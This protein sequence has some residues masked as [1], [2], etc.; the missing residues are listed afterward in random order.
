MFFTGLIYFCSG[1]VED[2]EKWGL[3][4]GNNAS[5]KGL[6]LYQNGV[7][8]KTRFNKRVVKVVECIRKLKLSGR[9]EGFCIQGT[10]RSSVRLTE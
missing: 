8:L 7:I 1:V 2:G 5:L 3:I 4:L 10:T 6:S 9:R